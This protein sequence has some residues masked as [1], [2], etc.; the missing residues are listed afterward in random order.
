LEIPGAI[1]FSLQPFSSIFFFLAGFFYFT[2][3]FLLVLNW[4]W[5]GISPDNNLPLI[6]NR[7]FYKFNSLAE[8]KVYNIKGNIMVNAQEWLDKE[9]PQQEEV[10][11]IKREREI[12]KITGKLTI[13]DF[14]QIEK[15][16]V[17]NNELAQLHLK[18]C[19]QLTYLDCSDNKLTKLTI[20]DCP[21]LQKIFA[22]NDQLTNL[23]LSNNQ[24]LEVL[25]LENNNFSSDLFFLS[26]LVDLQEI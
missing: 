18:N 11:E 20:T 16:D 19:P 23:D 15:I 13:A 25:S 2:K 6:L 7:D 4:C 24:Q 8:K 26:H 9:Y 17:K 10:K 5:A 1:V 3:F 12:E 14:P 21:N 22:Y